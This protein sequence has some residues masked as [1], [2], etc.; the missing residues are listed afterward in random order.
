MRQLIAF[1]LL[2]S[3]CLWLMACAGDAPTGPDIAIVEK[4]DQGVPSPPPPPPPPP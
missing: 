4:D 1:L 2:V 3:C